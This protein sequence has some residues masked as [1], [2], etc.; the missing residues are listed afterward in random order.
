MPANV[1]A[2]DRGG[3]KVVGVIESAHDYPVHTLLSPDGN[4]TYRIPPYQREY[5]WQKP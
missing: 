3:R 5:S 4:L 1:A 2:E